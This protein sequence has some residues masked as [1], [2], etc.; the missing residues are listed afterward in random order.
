MEGV[1][2]CGGAAVGEAEVAEVRA[3]AEVGAGADVDIAPT[4]RM[5]AA[6]NRA[7]A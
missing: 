5:D 4:E 7:E 6:N 3:G 1:E 2:P